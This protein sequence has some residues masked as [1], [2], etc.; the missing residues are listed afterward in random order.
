MVL[1]MLLEEVRPLLSFPELNTASG[2]FHRP[3]C[4]GLPVFSQTLPPSP[5]RS[6]SKLNN[7]CESNQDENA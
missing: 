1:P 2:I 4:P 7:P 3:H 5:K 6:E